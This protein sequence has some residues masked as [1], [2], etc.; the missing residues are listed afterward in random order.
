MPHISGHINE[1]FYGKKAATHSSSS[2]F[3]YFVEAAEGTAEAQDAER[4]E[5]EEGH[6][7]D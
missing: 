6:P 1:A 2:L 4:E 7:D 5:G 3:A